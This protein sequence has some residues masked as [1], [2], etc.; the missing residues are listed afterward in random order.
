MARGDRTRIKGAEQERKNVVL[1]SGNTEDAGIPVPFPVTGIPASPAAYAL[2][3]S[4]PVIDIKSTITRP[5]G[6]FTFTSP[7]SR[8]YRVECKASFSVSAVPGNLAPYDRTV[9]FYF[10][11]SLYKNG[12]YI[13]SQQISGAS[14]VYYVSRLAGDIFQTIPVA[15]ATTTVTLF[16]NAGETITAKAT[17]NAIGPVLFGGVEVLRA[18]NVR[19]TSTFEAIEITPEA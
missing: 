10:E 13:N 14:V 9:V 1:Y 15:L 4:T 2:D 5:A 3:F 19:V 7:R 16:V 11:S 18:S 12:V 17:H 8:F 6:I